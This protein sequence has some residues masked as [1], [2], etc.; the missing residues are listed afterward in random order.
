[1]NIILIWILKNMGGCF[2]ASCDCRKAGGSEPFL[3]LQGREQ[4]LPLL[5]IQP[6]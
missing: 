1:M 4:S 6:Q 2:L 3:R 5:E